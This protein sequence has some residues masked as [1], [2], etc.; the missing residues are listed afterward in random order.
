MRN[1]M[2]V[3]SWLWMLSAVIQGL[4]TAVLTFGLLGWL[5]SGMETQVQ[6]PRLCGYP[7]AVSHA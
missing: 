1:E 2:R 7:E 6:A 4:L 3:T 5:L